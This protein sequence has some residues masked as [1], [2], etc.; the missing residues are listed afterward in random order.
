[1]TLDPEKVSIAIKS[2]LS[3]VCATCSNYWEARDKG[4]PGDKCL[5][6]NGCGS[7]IAGD[8]FH[9]YRG[10]MTHFDKFCFVCAADAT[11]AIRVRGNTRLIGCCSEHVDLVK[12]LKPKGKNSAR[13]TI[14]SD[15]GEEDVSEDTPEPPKKLKIE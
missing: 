1:M 2:G 15:D 3:A 10:P 12:T 9:E 5:A 6:V 4:I 8:V 11:H 7:P 14:H 13:I